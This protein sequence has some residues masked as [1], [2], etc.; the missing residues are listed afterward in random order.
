MAE[1]MDRLVNVDFTGRSIERLYKAARDFI[2]KPLCLHGGYK[3][4]GPQRRHH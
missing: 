2:G 4:L 3:R 1:R